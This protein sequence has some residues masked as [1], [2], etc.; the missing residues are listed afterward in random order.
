MRHPRQQQQAQQRQGPQQLL[1]VLQLQPQAQQVRLLAQ[2]ESQQPLLLAL[3]LHRRPAWPLL[4]QVMQAW[5]RA[6]LLLL[7]RRQASL[8]LPRQ[9]LLQLLPVLPRLLRLPP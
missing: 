4:L 2:Q 5:R 6:L 8:L 1:P 7:L 3:R 9:L